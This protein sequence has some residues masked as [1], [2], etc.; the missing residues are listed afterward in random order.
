MRTLLVLLAFLPLRAL[1]DCGSDADCKGERVCR[2]GQCEDPPPVSVGRA[3]R[4]V[5]WFHPLGTLAG[6]ILGSING[7]ALFMLP[8]QFEYGLQPNLSLTAT[9]T[10]EIASSGGVSAFGFALSTSARWFPLSNA[11]P[12]GF[13]AGG[14]LSL[15]VAGPFVV[16]DVSLG[17]G[18]QWLWESGFAIGVNG[19]LGFVS[20]ARGAMPIYLN[21]PIG[22]AF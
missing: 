8:V 2:S 11:A 7:Y 12:R 1:A 16:F 6:A 4:M 18:Y 10:P 20:L 17:V 19:G 21:V 15:E 5:L 14:G 3:P 13:F 22:F 9:V